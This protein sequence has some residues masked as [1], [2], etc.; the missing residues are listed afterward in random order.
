[1]SRRSSAGELVPRDISEIL[2]REGK[3]Q[4]GQRKTG[5][6]LGQTFSW[7]KGSKRKKNVSN[8]QN[9]MGSGIGTT[10][11]NGTKHGQHQNHD[12]PKVQLHTTILLSS[13]SVL[14]HLL[15]PGSLQT[16]PR[17][18]HGASPHVSETLQFTKVSGFSYIAEVSVYGEERGG[19]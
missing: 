14:L 13:Q 11:G 8:G 18:F 19:Q 17:G 4:R 6:S 5:G 2:A 16:K 3:A 1:M 12:S 10:E 9:R 15:M 7:L